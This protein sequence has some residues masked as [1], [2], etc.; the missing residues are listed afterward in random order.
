MVN[1][2]S[3]GTLE[4]VR[5]PMGCYVQGAR[6]YVGVSTLRAHRRRRRSRVDLA[7]SKRGPTSSPSKTKQGS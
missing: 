4:G 2:Q 6:V 5:S 7:A 3:L 1:A